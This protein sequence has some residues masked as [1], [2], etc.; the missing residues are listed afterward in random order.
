MTG[1]DDVVE[2]N[3]FGRGKVV[4][5]GLAN[6]LLDYDSSGIVSSSFGEEGG[7]RPDT[8]SVAIYFSEDRDTAVYPLDEVWKK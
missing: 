7:M 8:P 3:L 5:V 4:A 2:G 1:K 6:D